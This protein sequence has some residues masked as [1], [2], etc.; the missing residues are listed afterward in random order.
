MLYFTEQ[1]HSTEIKRMN[2]NIMNMHA[3]MHSTKARNASD[4]LND[5]N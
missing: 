2:C 5:I 3:D 1:P 4:F